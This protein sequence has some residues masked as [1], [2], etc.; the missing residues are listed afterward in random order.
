MARFRFSFWL[1]ANK[2]D[3]LLLM[4]DIDR[5]K[6][7]R[8]FSRTIRDGIRLMMDLRAGST[9]VLFE[10]FPQIEDHLRRQFS[11][12]ASDDNNGN[13]D[14][15]KAIKDKLERLEQLAIQQPAPAGYLM[16]AKDQSASGGPKPLGGLK[17][18]AAPGTDEDDTDLLEIKKDTSTD[19]GLNFLRSAMA[20][21][22]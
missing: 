22:Q 6:E 15:L 1:D 4:E 16:A 12:N 3:E 19:S 8:L 20:L 17:K 11:G 10:L 21:Q 9:D 14:D 2:D 18:V 5:L 7:K 13:G